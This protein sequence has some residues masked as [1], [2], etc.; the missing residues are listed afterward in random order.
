MSTP[1]SSADPWCVVPER[2]GLPGDEA[3]VGGAAAGRNA[4]AVR[5]RV[6]T[7][8]AVGAQISLAAT[9]FVEDG[10]L[11]WTVLVD[12]IEEELN[13]LCVPL[14]SAAFAEDLFGFA[15]VE[16]GPVGAAAGDGVPAVA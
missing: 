2:D 11:D 7:H 8:V 14:G 9:D 5:E 12:L 15:R 10:C 3:A 1:V 6:G 16:R 4:E 13:G